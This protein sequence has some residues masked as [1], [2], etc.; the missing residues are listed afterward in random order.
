MRFFTR[1]AA[2]EA[3]IKAASSSYLYDDSRITK[4]GFNDILIWPRPSG[5]A[6][7]AIL[8]KRRKR[9]VPSPGPLNTE[10]NASEPTHSHDDMILSSDQ[11]MEAWEDLAFLKD[12]DGD[13]IEISISHERDYAIAT[14]IFS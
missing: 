5:G 11:A 12:L 4:L 6:G 3:I 8:H 1:W 14:A 9:P 10:T 2:K 7:A 13:M